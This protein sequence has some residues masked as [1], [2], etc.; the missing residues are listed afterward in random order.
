[1]NKL[2][3]YNTVIRLYDKHE[4]AAESPRHEYA[5]RVRLQFEF[6]RDNISYNGIPLNDASGLDPKLNPQNLT[7]VLISKLVIS[8]YFKQISLS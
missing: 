1:L 3:K 5:E 7:Q 8:H 4:L 6:A 2:G